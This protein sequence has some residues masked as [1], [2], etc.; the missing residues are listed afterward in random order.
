M[1]WLLGSPLSSGDSGVGCGS[2][3]DV[4]RTRRQRRLVEVRAQRLPARCGLVGVWRSARMLRYMGLSS[5]NLHPDCVTMKGEFAVEARYMLSSPVDLA[6]IAVAVLLVFGPKKV[7]E[8]GKALGQGIGN[9]KKAL[10]D[11]QDEF[12]NAVNTDKKTD[13]PVAPVAPNTT[14]TACDDQPKQASQPVETRE[15]AKT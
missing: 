13:T 2:Q 8:F 4:A 6:M 3:F 9:F 14:T 11:A 7:P 12:S 5:R 15:E 10:S 1:R